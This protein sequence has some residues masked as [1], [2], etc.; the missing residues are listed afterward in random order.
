MAIE[1]SKERLDANSRLKQRLRATVPI[2]DIRAIKTQ[3]NEQGE[4]FLSAPPIIEREVS[5]K[6]ILPPSDEFMPNKAET[7]L[8]QLPQEKAATK[9]KESKLATFTLRVDDKVDKGLKSLCTQESISKETFLEAAY[10]VCMENQEFMQYVLEIATLRKQE[11][12]ETGIQRRA[13]AMTRYL[14]DD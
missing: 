14:Q 9:E 13:K 6:E 8:S 10:L 1:E 4:E 3:S 5:P 7:A 2:R 11:R 12:R